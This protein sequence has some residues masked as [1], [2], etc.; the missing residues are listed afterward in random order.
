[1]TVFVF[2][3]V[4]NPTAR[5]TKTVP[6]LSKNTLMSHAAALGVSSLHYEEHED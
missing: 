1:M 3:T 2:L 6:K 5:K 4:P